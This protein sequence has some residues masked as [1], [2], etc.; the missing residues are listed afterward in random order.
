MAKDHFEFIV[1][2]LPAFVKIT[3]VKQVFVV[4]FGLFLHEP[5]AK[6]DFLQKYIQIDHFCEEN[7]GNKAEVKEGISD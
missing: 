5:L 3:A 7:I 6:Y 1:F 4:V 2:D